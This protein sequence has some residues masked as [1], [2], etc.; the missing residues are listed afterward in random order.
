MNAKQQSVGRL[1]WTP[2]PVIVIIRD[3][4]DYIRILIFLIYHYYRVVGSS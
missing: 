1:R 4:K 2:H 3:N